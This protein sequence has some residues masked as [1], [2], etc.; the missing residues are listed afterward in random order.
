MFMRR[1]DVNISCLIDGRSARVVSVARLLKVLVI[2]G[3]ETKY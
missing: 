1:V 2:R 3:P